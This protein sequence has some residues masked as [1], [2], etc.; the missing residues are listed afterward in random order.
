MKADVFKKLI[1][2]SVRE[3]FRE[4]LKEVLLESLKSSRTSSST[5]VTGT[6]TTTPI[7][8]VPP[9]NL[10]ESRKKY[11]DVLNET[12]GQVLGTN[13]AKPMQ[14]RGSVDSINGALPEGDVGLDMI[15]NLVNSK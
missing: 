3:V 8:T 11:M 12:Q 4:E 13:N 14:V 2:E 9:Q 5:I 7:Q 1:K 15:M 10:A 6:T